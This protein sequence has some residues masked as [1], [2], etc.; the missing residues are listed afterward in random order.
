L[1][2]AVWFFFHS[3]CLSDFPF[4]CWQPSYSFNSLFS[5]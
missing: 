4:G 5:K 3:L 2:A 1:C